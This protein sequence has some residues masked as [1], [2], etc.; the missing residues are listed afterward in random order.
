VL[1]LCETCLGFFGLI[2]DGVVASTLCAALRR[3][4]GISIRR[5]TDELITNPIGKKVT[6]GF[7]GIGEHVTDSCVGILEKVSK[8]SDSEAK[9]KDSEYKE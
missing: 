8:L 5:Y 3:T 9:K 7:F 1:L 6:S 2:F 4:T